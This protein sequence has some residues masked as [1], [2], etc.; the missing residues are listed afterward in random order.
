MSDHTDIED[1]RTALIGRSVTSVE[2]GPTDA[3]TYA[4]GKITLDDGTSLLLSGNDGCGGCPSGNYSLT[5]LNDMP[6]N[7][8]TNVEI[9]T[10]ELPD[11]DQ[12]YR[13]FVLA[14]DRR[15]A[16]AE[17]QGTDGNGWYGTGF[18]FTVLTPTPA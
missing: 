7:G 1:L 11:D 3:P 13:I 2:F 18:W 10:E 12:A 17:F 9:V 15:F 14:E 16:L 4:E 5:L 6:V 8:I